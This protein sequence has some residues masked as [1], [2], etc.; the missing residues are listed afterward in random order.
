MRHLRRVFIAL[1][2]V[3]LAGGLAGC[4]RMMDSR[5]VS[6][7]AD[8]FSVG[9]LPAED[10][11]TGLLPEAD[12]PLIQ[13][14]GTDDGPVDMIARQAIT[15]IETFWDEAYQ[16]T[17]TGTFKQVAELYSWDALEPKRQRFCLHPTFRFANAVYCLMD[18]TIGWDRGVML[19]VLRSAYGDMA[20]TMV[21]AHEYGHALSRMARLTKL[22]TPIL[23]RE[24]Q[25]DCLAGVYM[26]W[27]AEGKSTRFQLGTGEGLN[28]LL[29][30][31]VGI[32][33]PV[34]V[35]GES[36][37]DEH[38]SAF[39]RI[40]AF[41][42]GFTE[43]AR[44]C[45][46][47]D[48]EQMDV[49]REGLPIALQ[50]DTTGEWPVT[51]ESVRTIVDDLNARFTPAEPPRL[52][53]DTDE[54]CADARSSPPASYC[55]ESN[56]LIVDLPDLIEMGTP[57]AEDDL[58]FETA[59]SMAGDNT[60]YSVLVSRYM[61]ALQH[62]RGGLALDTAQAG[63]RTACMTGATTA[64]L[65]TPFTREDRVTITL[66]AGDL[67]EAVT[68][69]LTNGIAASD[70]NGD[71]VPAGFARIDAFRTGVL[72]DVDRCIQRFP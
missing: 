5:P 53:F 44:S 52:S 16:R 7:Y 2:V 6:V 25:A 69:L 38:G 67:D 59:L 47:I 45:A 34:P 13:V 24:Q 22:D 46:L 32:R 41:Q 11:P 12:K 10:N 21:L 72:G 64:L 50:E 58:S 30:V 20:I 62:Q 65:A 33:D 60:A 39:E 54:S 55:P 35:E 14:T 15:D 19:P 4:T 56:T 49:R 71:A 3:L 63:L 61:L 66:S 27:V 17:F 29:A 1:C 37:D 43:G 40:S 36:P 26:R 70:V 31:M 48:T 28:D 51:E 8:P 57:P 68:G 42:F 23:V 18:N 9:G